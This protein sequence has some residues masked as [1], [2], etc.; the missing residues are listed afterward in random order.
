MLFGMQPRQR[1]CS[2]HPNAIIT[3][4]NSSSQRVTVNYGATTR[5][6]DF[7]IIHPPFYLNLNK[8]SEKYKNEGNSDYSYCVCCSELSGKPK[9]GS[10][11]TLA[12]LVAR[13]KIR[14]AIYATVAQPSGVLMDVNIRRL[15]GS[16]AV[17]QKIASLNNLIFAA[18]LTVS[19]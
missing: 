12:Q 8:L 15:N 6:D 19:K 10:D 14:A 13:L 11:K 1:L 9:P 16:A 5:I 2:Y 3:K 4:V 18:G 7:A 17:N